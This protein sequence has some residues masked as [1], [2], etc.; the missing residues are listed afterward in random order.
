MNE[1]QIFNSAEFGQIRTVT[2]DNEPW[3]VGYDV[4]D[5]LGYKNQSDAVLN[6]VDE[7]D[8]RVFQKSEITTLASIP[9]RGLTCINESGLYSLI[10]GSKLESA[11][12]F[13]HWV[14]SE[15]LPSIRKNGAT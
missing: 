9:N 10:L 3:F 8:R 13:K 15:V 4:A 2:K 1:L 12:R 7:D 11:K 5:A 14:T 6:H